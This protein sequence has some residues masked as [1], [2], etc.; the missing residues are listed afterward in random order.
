MLYHESFARGI[1]SRDHENTGTG[2]KVQ[3]SVSEICRDILSRLLSA[4]K[5]NTRNK[6]V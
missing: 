1:Y 4:M 6:A 3:L 2:G 5:Q